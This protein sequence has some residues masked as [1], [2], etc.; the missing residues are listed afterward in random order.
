MPC[1]MNTLSVND[2]TDDILGIAVNEKVLPLFVVNT[3]F[4][5]QRYNCAM[6]S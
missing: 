2:S 5:E 4:R 6:P 3:G 1:C